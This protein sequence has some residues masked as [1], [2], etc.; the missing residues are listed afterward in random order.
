MRI[1]FVPKLG[2]NPMLNLPLDFGRASHTQ[3]QD[4]GQRN[5]GA[6]LFMTSGKK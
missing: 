2:C 5:A 4:L 3:M 6:D 1:D